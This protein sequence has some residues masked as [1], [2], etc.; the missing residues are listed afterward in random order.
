MGIYECC[1]HLVMQSPP[2]L[3]ALMDLTLSVLLASLSSCQL[4][5]VSSAV[6]NH[7][8]FCWPSN[9]EPILLWLMHFNRRNNLFSLHAQIFSPYY[10]EYVT[11]RT[12]MWSKSDQH[13][14]CC[15][16]ETVEVFLQNSSPLKW[17][18][19]FTFPHNITITFSCFVQR[20]CFKYRVGLLL[21]VRTIDCNP[22]L[23]N[24]QDLFCW[25]FEQN[26]KTFHLFSLICVHTCIIS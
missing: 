22:V 15:L 17:E 2:I 18:L 8:V 20:G 9:A 7:F 14:K 26:Y 13:R 16:K 1:R 5:L 21:H 19:Y 12:L 23:L 11:P 25:Y 6:S 10:N 4:V 3:C 24:R